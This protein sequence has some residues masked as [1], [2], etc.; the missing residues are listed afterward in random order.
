MKQAEDPLRD[1]SK[2]FQ[3][4]AASYREIARADADI[5]LADHGFTDALRTQAM[6]G[7]EASLVRSAMH[8]ALSELA[9][10]IRKELRERS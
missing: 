10:A 6:V 2:R 8:E 4:I 5:I 3:G 7:S 1:L 9:E